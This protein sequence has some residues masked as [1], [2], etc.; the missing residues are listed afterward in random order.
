MIDVFCR[1]VQTITIIRLLVFRVSGSNESDRAVMELPM[2]CNHN[3]VYSIETDDEDDKFT[4]RIGVRIK[5][6]PSVLDGNMTQVNFSL[7]LTISDKIWV[8]TT[9]ANVTNKMVRCTL[10][11]LFKVSLCVHK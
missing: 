2:V 10:I 1:H 7:G 6:L 11:L 8:Y 9:T 4:L 5:D 3:A